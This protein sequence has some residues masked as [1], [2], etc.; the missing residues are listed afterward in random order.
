MSPI[1]H[2]KD[3]IGR[4][5]AHDS[6]PA[7]TK[8]ELLLR[9]QAIWNSLLQADIQNMFDSPPRR[10]VGSFHNL[11]LGNYCMALKSS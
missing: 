5:L 3:L 6:R 8:D 1:E 7:A 11:A 2:V 4:R 10:T 9:K